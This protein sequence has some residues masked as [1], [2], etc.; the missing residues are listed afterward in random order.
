MHFGSL[1]QM[2]TF[3][4]TREQATHQPW[5]RFETRDDAAIA[6]SLMSIGWQNAFNREMGAMIYSVRDFSIQTRSF[7]T[8]Y[9]FGRAWIG[10]EDNVAFG[11]ISRAN[12]IFSITEWDRPRDAQAVALAHTHPEG[13]R[14]FSDEDMNIADGRYNI[15]GLGIPAMAVYVAVSLTEGQAASRGHD[16]E[17]RVFEGGMDRTGPTGRLGDTGRMVFTQ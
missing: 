3:G 2:D 11:F 8:Y 15:F 12:N 17:I 14:R 7:E 5:D 9:T 16:F 6:F 10:R 4:F 13:Y 1:V